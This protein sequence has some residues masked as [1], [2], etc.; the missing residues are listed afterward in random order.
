MRHESIRTRFPPEPKPT[1]KLDVTFCVRG[2]ISP[3][4]ANIYLHYTLDI[5]VKHWRKEAKGDVIYLRYADD[6]V[7]G[8]QHE[9]EA[10]KSLKEVE[11]RMHL[12]GLELHPEKTRLIEF[13]R[14]AEGNRKRRGEGKTG[15]LRF[16]GI[17]AQVRDDPEG[18][19]V[20]HTT[21]DGEKAATEQAA[22]NSAEVTETAKR[23]VGGGGEMAAI[24][25]AGVLQLSCDTG[26]LCGVGNVPAGSGSSVAV[27]DEPT[28]PA[29][30]TNVGT[31][32]RTGRAFSASA[33]HP[34]SITNGAV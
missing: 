12:R 16:S 8:F 25:G 30:A 10:R 7:A 23:A 32:P 1:V 3:L 15:S 28:Q 17:H 11:E 14:F 22:G 9:W 34:A 20:H 33:A 27:G 4:L 6:A 18:Q 26:E 31:V 5:W 19:V 24:G 21:T 2:V 13:G 29:R